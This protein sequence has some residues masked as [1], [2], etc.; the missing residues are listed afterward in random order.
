MIEKSKNP[1]VISVV[2]PKRVG[3]TTFINSL[4]SYY[5]SSQQ[6]IN[7]GSILLFTKEKSSY[8]FIESPSDKLSM[9]N[10]A[11]ASDIIIL[12]ID[13]YFGLELETFEFLS[14]SIVYGCPR[15]LCVLTHLDL[16]KDWKTLRKAKK[17]IKKRLQS[18]LNIHSKIFFFSGITLNEKYLTREISNFTRYLSNIHLYPSILQKSSSYIVISAVRINTINNKQKILLFGFAKGKTP[19]NTLNIFSYIPGIGDIEILNVYNQKFDKKEKIILNKLSSD[20]CDA[21]FFYIAHNIRILNKVNFLNSNKNI[22]KYQSFSFL[23]YLL[24]IKKRML[25]TTTLNYKFLES[26]KFFF[27]YKIN[28]YKFS[29]KYYFEQKN[30]F[31][32]QIELENF[33]NNQINCKENIKKKKII[34]NKI[35]DKYYIETFKILESKRFPD[36]FKRY[37]DPFYPIIIE[38]NF[39]IKPKTF[40]AKAKIIKHKWNKNVLRSNYSY[41][42]SVGWKIFKTNLIFFREDSLNR[43]RYQKYLSSNTSTLVCFYSILI[44]AGVVVIGINEENAKIRTRT[45]GANFNILFTGNILPNNNSLNIVKKAKLKGIIYNSFRK[46]AFIKNMFSS[47]IEISRFIGSSIQTIS[48]IRGV[49]K[50]PINNGP[51]GSFRANFEKNIISGEVIFLRIWFPIQI[52]KKLEYKN[53]FDIPN[54]LREMDYQNFL[55]CLNY[56]EFLKKEHEIKILKN[57]GF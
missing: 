11:K 25:V 8:L 41:V 14:L 7:E 33:F 31:N 28:N 35:Y 52:S 13:C 24:S 32:N 45:Q 17:R 4:I 56:T 51:N 9:I 18:E 50:K 30:D 47:E 29:L 6:Y 12:V 34:T 57:F 16:F 26:N 10:L 22:K 42:I 49:I 37:F 2:G 55:N 39:G 27:N 21:A 20:N 19:R 53:F 15:V 5:S 46:T 43:N 40:I 23:L 54:D 1:V 36:Q 3:K 48:G 44:E 38:I